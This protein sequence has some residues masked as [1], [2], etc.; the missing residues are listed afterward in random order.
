MKHEALF[1]G[2]IFPEIPNEMCHGST[3]LPV[4]DCVLAAWFAGSREGEDDVAI[5]VS[6]FVNGQWRVPQVIKLCSEPHWNPVLT[7]LGNGKLA[8]YFKVGRKIESWR[9]M[10]CY[11]DKLGD[12]WS[13][14]VELVPG[15]RGGRGPVRCKIIRLSNGRLLAP[16]S[17]EKNGTWE[18]FVDRSDDNGR[19]W[20]QS[21]LIQIE[22]HDYN[23]EQNIVMNKEIE[24]SEQSF[25]GRGVI[26]PTLWESAPGRVHMLLRSTEGRIYRSDSDDYGKSWCRAYPTELPNNNSGIDVV[27]IPD[28][29]LILAYNPVAKNWGPR[30][31]LSLAV[32][33]DNGASWTKMLD[34]DSGDGEFSYPALTNEEDVLH[35]TYTWKRKT[36]AYWQIEIKRG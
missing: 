16:A 2:F 14:P 21:N 17:L 22:N 18:A 9:T 23:L 27:K 25:H 11:S 36:V 5:K 35:L 28:G 7:D 1:R 26:Q 4:G 8:L 32:S 24:V 10:V 34:L 12:T 29:T 3:V 20:Q 30:T 15:D 33:E 13:L 6:K 31:P 19:T